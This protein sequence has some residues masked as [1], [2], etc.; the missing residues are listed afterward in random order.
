MRRLEFF[1]DVK[2]VYEEEE[3]RTLWYLQ[4]GMEMVS[5]RALCEEW[6]K[7]VMVCLAT[8]YKSVAKKARPVNEAMPQNLNPSLQSPNLSRYLYETP[9]YMQPLYFDKTSR[10]TQEILKMVSFGPEGWLSE[11][12]MKLILSV[13]LL[14]E[15]AIAFDETEWGFLKNEWGMPFV[16]PVVDHKLLQKWEIPIPKAI[17]E[18]HTE[19]VR[20]RTRTGLYE[21]STL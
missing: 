8:K 15:K 18:N 13:I 5:E 16:V 11:E 6:K 19:L 14:R 1:D 12:E 3:S 2:G 7:G 10:V 9:L 4:K 21:Q 17:K 20:E